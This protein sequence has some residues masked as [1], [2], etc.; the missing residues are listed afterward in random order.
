MFL[1]YWIFDAH[2]SWQQKKKKKIWSRFSF[3]L[4]YSQVMMIPKN[5]AFQNIIHEGRSQFL[6]SLI[7]FKVF[8]PAFIAVLYSVPLLCFAIILSLYFFDTFFIPEIV[9]VPLFCWLCHVFY[10]HW[11]IFP[12]VMPF[13]HPPKLW[14]TLMYGIEQFPCKWPFFIEQ[15][16][17][18]LKVS[19]Y[20]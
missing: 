7:Q 6:K 15:V 9:L 14:R 17:Q 16:T 1:E 4:L 8:L 3:A 2:Q 5:T 13:N 18:L 12:N 11:I 19:N 10:I 20:R